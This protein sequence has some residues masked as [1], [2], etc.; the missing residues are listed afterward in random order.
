[1][2]SP[3]DARW[4]VPFAIAVM[5]Y[6]TGSGVCSGLLLGGRMGAVVGAGLAGLGAGIGLFLYRRRALASFEAVTV[7]GRAEGV[8]DMVLLSIVLYQAA[9]FP[10]TPGG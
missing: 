6:M 8:A 2:T 9:V 5:V 10:L 1:M 3:L 7:D 4:Y